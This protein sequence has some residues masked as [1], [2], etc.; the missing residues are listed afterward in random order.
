MDDEHPPPP[1]FLPG[2]GLALQTT[3]LTD[4]TTSMVVRTSVA[5]DN[6]PSAPVSSHSTTN[7]EVN[8]VS[9]APT[10]SSTYVTLEPCT[11]LPRQNTRKQKF[12]P[13]PSL[14][15]LFDTATWTKYCVIP[16]SSPTGD[17]VDFSTRLLQHVGKN[18]VFQ[19]RD[20]GTRTVTVQN[21]AQAEA[22]STL[23][24]SNGRPMSPAETHF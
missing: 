14:S 16:S 18:V 1:D 11:R 15:S 8:S 3:T 5:G 23:C 20:D 19:S 24:D 6:P 12:H 9:T 21:E 13:L 10:T 7:A 2:D 17:D 22:M 4:P